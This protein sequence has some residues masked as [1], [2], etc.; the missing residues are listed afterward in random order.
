MKFV[1]KLENIDFSGV[2][3]IWKKVNLS[4]H[5]HVRERI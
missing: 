2:K 1:R 5:V 3:I 4:T